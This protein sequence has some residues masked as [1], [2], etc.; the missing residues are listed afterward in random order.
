MDHDYAPELLKMR[1]DYAEVKAALKEKNIRFQTPFPARLWVYYK[2]GTVIYNSAE[3]VTEDMAD[4]GIP[5]TV[6]KKT[7]SLLDQISQLSWQPSGRRE[8]RENMSAKHGFKELLQRFRRQD[9]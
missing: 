2:E 7:T 9:T 1:R 4:R 8:N 6:L 5:V 3:A